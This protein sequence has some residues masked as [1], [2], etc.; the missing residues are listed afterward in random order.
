MVRARRRYVVGLFAL[1]LIVSM[2]GLLLY[3]QD[4]EPVLREKVALATRMLVRARML[5][6]SGHVS[7][8]IPGTDR[9][10][11]GPGNLSRNLVTP[12][13]IVTIDLNSEHQSLWRYVPNRIVAHADGTLPPGE[14]EIHT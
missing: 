3:S 7:A 1:V 10:L 4:P 12:D 2:G 9:V 11:I 13:D 14:A 8:R 6:Q 5:D